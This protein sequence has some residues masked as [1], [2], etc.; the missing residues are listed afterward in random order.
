GG[1]QAMAEVM[2]TQPKKHT[3]S[4][5][6]RKSAKISGISEVSSYDVNAVV[7]ESDC[8]E[9]IIQ[10]SSLHIN[11]FDQSSGNLLLEGIIESMQYVNIKPKG[12]S[13]FA[14]ILK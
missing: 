4:I 11:S 2:N 8:G 12:E 14:R 5:E 3:V 9:L 13:F 7:V 10:G 1:A 6:D